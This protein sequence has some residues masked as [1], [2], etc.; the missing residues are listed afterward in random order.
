[1]QFSSTKLAYLSFSF[2]SSPLPSLLQLL[3]FSNPFFRTSSLPTSLRSFSFSLSLS[4]CYFFPILFPILSPILSL[5]LFAFLHASLL[6]FLF[7]LFIPFPFLI[8]SCGWYI[9]M[10]S[11]LPGVKM[12]KRGSYSINPIFSTSLLYVPLFIYLLF[13]NLTIIY[14]LL[15]GLRHTTP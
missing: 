5:F 14:H 10:F 1:M 8:Y 2:L 3:F 15:L 9:L 13:G 11:N 4:F 6:S 12:S 7:L